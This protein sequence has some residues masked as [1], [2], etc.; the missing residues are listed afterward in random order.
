[1]TDPRPTQLV[2]RVPE[3][4]PSPFDQIRSSVIGAV[5]I[6][7]FQLPSDCKIFDKL[8]NDA[9]NEPQRYAL[10]LDCLTEVVGDIRAENAALQRQI[11]KLALTRSPSISQPTVA[12]DVEQS[13]DRTGHILSISRMAEGLSKALTFYE[14]GSH[15]PSWRQG[16]EPICARCTPALPQ[17]NQVSVLCTIIGHLA[18]KE[19]GG[20]YRGPDCEDNCGALGCSGEGLQATRH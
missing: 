5:D 9:L 16:V 12:S 10:F 3:D 2:L 8:N 17:C 15:F 19:S 18:S 1:M 4:L 13:S 14:Q 7:G 11:T 6:T 20:E